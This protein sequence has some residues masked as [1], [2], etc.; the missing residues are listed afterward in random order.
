M[1]RIGV[2]VGGT[3]TDL[4]YSDDEAR[5]GFVEKVPST[6]EDPSIAVIDGVQRLCQKPGLA[7]PKLTSSYTAPRWQPTPL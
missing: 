6:P 2:D 7:L 5:T 4:Y 1:K 3:F